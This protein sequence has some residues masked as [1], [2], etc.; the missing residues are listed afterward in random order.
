MSQRGRKD[1]TVPLEEGLE[2]FH[3][4]STNAL[5]K[6]ADL[7]LDP[8]G[9]RPRNLNGKGYFDGR[10]PAN[11]NSM[12]LQD[13]GDIFS[14]TERYSN[15]L[16]GYV[17]VAKAALKNAE[18]RLKLAKA[19]VRKSKSGSKEERDD[20]TIIDERYHN[21][22]LQWQEAFEY[23]TMLDGLAAAARSN[24]KT[25]SRLFEPKKM[26]YEQGRRLD[27]T[28]RPGSRRGGSRDPLR[29]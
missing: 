25:I 23:F 8:M 28:R 4:A 18:G 1:Y 29:R 13:L 12:S 5:G 16:T 9:D 14:L 17:T 27:N 15:W 20:D 10:L 11:L 3:T 26:E 7:G 6:L 22:M 24:H 2:G 21:E 19:R